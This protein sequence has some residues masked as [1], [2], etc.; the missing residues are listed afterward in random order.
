MPQKQLIKQFILENF[1]F[2]DDASAIGDQ[3]SL[4]Q[5]GIV[6]STG[7]HELVFFLEDTFKL[8]IVPEEMIPANFDSIQTVD[9]FVSRKLAG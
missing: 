6:D 5:T 8:Q 3:D 1:L 4:I 2:S 9:D 7:I